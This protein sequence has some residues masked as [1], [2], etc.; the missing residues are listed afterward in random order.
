VTVATIQKT[1]TL[2]DGGTFRY[3]LGRRWAEGAPLVFI[4]LNPSTADADVDDATIRR[5]IRFAHAH[6]YPA[7]D[8]VNLF[9]YRATDPKDLR[10]AGYPV[11]PEND[12]HIASAARHAA[13]VCL[14]WGAH[15]AGLERPQV[16][17]PMLWKL[18]IEPM[19]L[20]I[21]RSGYP[22]HPLMLPADCRLIPF[23]TEAV[24][25]AMQP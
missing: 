21:T 4:M 14:A 18:G 20:R 3:R 8:V 19:C 22:Q 2:S 16:V 24:Q 17:M 25:E 6:G 11:G 23:T 7:I 10:R 1:A 15:V 5:C 12:D 13:A 9:A